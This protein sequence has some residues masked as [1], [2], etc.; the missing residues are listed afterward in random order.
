M[1]WLARINKHFSDGRVWGFMANAII[2]FLRILLI[3]YE[4]PATFGI[5]TI[6]LTLFVF[7]FTFYHSLLFTFVFPANISFD[8]ERNWYVHFRKCQQNQ[9]TFLAILVL[10]KWTFAKSYWWTSSEIHVQ[11]RF[12]GFCRRRVDHFTLMCSFVYSLFAYLLVLH[13]Q[14]L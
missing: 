9:L 13:V 11:L 12:R 2:C 7:V 3:L 8:W 1:L 4:I 6:L 10:Y 14:T 5:T